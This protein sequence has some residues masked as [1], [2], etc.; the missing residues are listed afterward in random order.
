MS[1]YV[2]TTLN[3]PAGTNGT[4]AHGINDSGQIVGTYQNATGKHGFLESGGT[5]ITLDDPYATLGTTNA[6]DINDAGQIVGSFQNATGSHGFHLEWRSTI[7]WAPKAPLNG[8]STFSNGPGSTS[9]RVVGSYQDATGVHGFL[10]SIASY[11]TLIDGVYT[12]VDTY[13]TIDGPAGFNTGAM[14]I[15][16]AGQIVGS[17]QDA[18]GVHGF[19]LSGGTYTTL[20]DPLATNGTYANDINDAGEIVGYYQNASGD[21]GFLFSGGTYTTLDDPASFVTDAPGISNT[22]A[23]S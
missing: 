20:D 7:L 11:Y 9:A 17:Y 2:Y 12:P 18:K 22:G 14:G 10:L 1:V 19:L 16:R 4:G 13:T 8:I 23:G 5:Y 6:S 3:A 15:N 21:H